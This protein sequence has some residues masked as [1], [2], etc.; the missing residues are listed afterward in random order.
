MIKLKRIAQTETETFGVLIKDDMP[1]CVTL[2]DPWKKNQKNISCIPAGKY[3]CKPFD[4]AKFK[5]VWILENVPNR[6]YILIHAG[7]SA[8]DTQGCILVGRSFNA[9]TIR[10][11][12]NALD[13]LRAV[14]PDEFDLFIENHAKPD[15]FV[16]PPKPVPFW[17]ELLTKLFG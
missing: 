10:D 17:D 4:G 16:S 1:L 8:V 11:S 3:K 13:Y 5:D 2:E 14:L 15:V 12:Q 7:N 9:H 6:S